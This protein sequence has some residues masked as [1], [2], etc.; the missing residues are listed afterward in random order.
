MREKHRVSFRGFDGP[1]VVE[2]NNEAVG[3][4]QGR[5]GD[6]ALVVESDWRTGEIECSPPVEFRCPK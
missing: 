5:A 1:Q 6:L 4:E 3:F 2:L